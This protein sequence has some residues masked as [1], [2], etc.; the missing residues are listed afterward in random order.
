MAEE[1][2]HGLHI[3]QV[4]FEPGRASPNLEQM[5]TNKNYSRLLARSVP[6]RKAVE[7]FQTPIFCKRTGGAIIFIIFKKER[8]SSGFVFF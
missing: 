3:F 8:T 6:S 7:V 5:F 1:L 2:V 4:S